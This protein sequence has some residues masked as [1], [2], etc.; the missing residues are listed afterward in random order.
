MYN[1]FIPTIKSMNAKNSLNNIK[2]G[3]GFWKN[4]L[5]RTGN[6]LAVGLNFMEA[7]SDTHKDKSTA[8]RTGRALAGTVL[9]IGAAYAGATAGAAIGTIIFPGVGTVVGGFVGAAVEKRLEGCR[10]CRKSCVG[11]S[12]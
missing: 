7:F 9:D 12:K 11:C 6:V 8:Q 3:G 4:N 5:A 2:P 10:R 1:N